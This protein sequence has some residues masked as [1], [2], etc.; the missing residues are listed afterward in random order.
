MSD[1]RRRDF[2]NPLK[3][4]RAFR[5]ES[6]E[7]PIS[8]PA[9]AMID[10]ADLREDSLLF[11]SKPAMACQFQIYFSP[12]A[13][14]EMTE[15]A[16]EALELVEQL[17]DQMTIYR[18][19][20]MTYLNQTAHLEPVRVEHRL[21]KLIQK[22]IE[23]FEWTDG[24]FDMTSGLLTKAWGF[25]RKQGQV[26]S[27]E[28]IEQVLRETGSNH[29]RVDNTEETIFFDSHQLEINLGAIGK[30]H[31]LDRAAEYLLQ[32]GMDHFLIHGGQSSVLAGGY[33]WLPPK[34]PEEDGSVEAK[35]NR[36]TVQDP[37]EQWKVGLRHPIHADR[38]LAVLKLKGEQALGTS[39]TARQ[40]FYHQGKRYGHIIDPRTGI[41][42]EG[43]Y[44]ATALAP[45]AAEA[46]ALATAFYVMGGPDAKAF[47]QKHPQYS[48][49]VLSPGKS[50]DVQIDMEGI[51]SD[52]IELMDVR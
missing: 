44:S 29:I 18:D 3:A 28:E 14:E 35:R 41:P 40:S 42:A 30:G 49:L 5:E 31:A 4:I 2:L 46:D 15:T 11:V 10:D 37:P 13:S 22:G 34:E 25:F 52:D 12:S 26:P 43:V 1:S 17:E 38:R 9:P 33:R 45:T 20:P 51:D 36:K 6:V 50:G 47:C 48:C 27:A 32:S 23:L 19:S 8:T 21:F 16:I 39:G 7:Q 24:A